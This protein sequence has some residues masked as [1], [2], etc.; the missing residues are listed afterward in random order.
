M[1]DLLHEAAT[2][3]ADGGPRTLGVR[4]GVGC[5]SPAR[6]RFRPA[7]SAADA[8]ACLGRPPHH[9]APT[10]RMWNVGRVVKEP[11]GWDRMRT[12]SS[13]TIV[14][15]PVVDSDDP[16]MSITFPLSQSI[17]TTRQTLPAATN[18]V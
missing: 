13:T 12:R 17:L 14:S 16:H 5:S 10:S 6:Q 3:A 4:R 15:D 11:A 7:T 2:S 1:P 9:D 18:A 8:D